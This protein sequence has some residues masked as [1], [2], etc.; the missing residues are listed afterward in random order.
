MTCE[1]CQLVLR[2]ALACA[3]AIARRLFLN[4]PV[5]HW[6]ITHRIYGMLGRL[7]VPKTADPVLT[8]RGC[9]FYY[10]AKDTMLSV[11]LMNQYYE[12]GTL[13]LF[14]SR[15]RSIAEERAGAQEVAVVDVG[16]NIGV[17]SVIAA[18]QGR[19]GLKVHSFEPNPQT[20]ALLLKNRDMNDCANI[21]AHCAAVGERKGTAQFDMSSD[22]VGTHRV[23]L[24]DDAADRVPIVCLDDLFGAGVRVGVIKID[25][26][27]YEPFVVRGA[28]AIIERDA[29]EIIMEFVPSL[30]VSNGVDPKG[31]LGELMA[32]YRRI[33]AIDDISGNLIPLG[34]L[35]KGEGFRRLMKSGGNMYLRAS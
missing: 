14:E 23:S 27:G 3:M 18:R 21:T 9:R 1:K 29:P 13:A 26:E 30:L 25:V 17:F 8:F 12:A 15:V 16:A 34:A 22:F 28:R 10:D 24:L 6:S 7:M 11:A 31:F 32:M 19:H 35:E 2:S 20:F 33:D 5:R 4:T